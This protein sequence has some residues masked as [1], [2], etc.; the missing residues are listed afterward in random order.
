MSAESVAGARE[1]SPE[2]L[3]RKLRGDLEHI[4]MMALRKEPHLRYASAEQF[5][6]DIRRYAEGLPVR[7]RQ[8][9]WTYR[10]SRFVRRHK[11][12]LGAVALFMLSL[13]GLSAIANRERLR[14]E[15]ESTKANAVIEFL[16]TTLGAIDPRV[17]QG[18][19]PTV[20][21]L[22]DEAETRL[23]DPGSL[24]Y[25]EEAAIREVIAE[26]RFQLGHLRQARDQ[27][28]QLVMSSRA[29]LGERHPDTLSALAGLAAA[30]ADLGELKEA[31]K[32]ARLAVQG[33]EGTRTRGA[34]HGPTSVKHTDKRSF[35]VRDQASLDRSRTDARSRDCP[36]VNGL[37][38]R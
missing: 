33:S 18:A 30:Q 27:Y 17:A 14:A 6:D 1:T 29:S 10:A 5:S 4:L 32:H 34:A 9:T 26:S 25:A 28:A 19:D 11:V 8:G 24:P 38:R 7:A 15:R 22:L 21:Q 31:E 23:S 16:T 36:R 35:A 12:G 20:R 13:I 3:R 2:K 37:Q